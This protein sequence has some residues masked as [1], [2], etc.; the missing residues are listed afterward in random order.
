[1]AGVQSVRLL[2][3]NR[4]ALTPSKSIAFCWTG[5]GW[6]CIGNTNSGSS[7][8]ATSCGVSVGRPA[9]GVLKLCTG[10]PCSVCLPSFAYVLSPAPAP[11]RPASLA[12]APPPG[13]AP[14]T[15]AAPA[16]AEAVPRNSQQ[17][18]QRVPAH[19][20]PVV[21]IHRPHLQLPTL[22]RAEH[23]LHLRQ[24]LVASTTVLC[25]PAARP[26]GRFG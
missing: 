14:R 1:M 4:A 3:R 25:A 24:A 12:A 21:D 10:S 26:Q 2:V 5:V 17:A 9:C 11:S 7:G 22:Q 23:P 16:A 13:P 6:A 19:V 20:I 15:A 8:S 18:H